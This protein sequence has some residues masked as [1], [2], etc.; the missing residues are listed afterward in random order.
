MLPQRGMPFRPPVGS[1]PPVGIPSRTPSGSLLPPKGVLGSPFAKPGMPSRNS[2]LGGKSALGAVR[3]PAPPKAPPTTL[4]G[5]KKY[6]TKVDMRQNIKKLSPFILKGKVFTQQQRAKMIEQWF[7]Y[8]KFGTHITEQK[9]KAVLRQLRR[10]ETWAKPKEK[11]PLKS[12]R[13]LL[14]AFTRVRKY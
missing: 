12:S 10:K 14:E 2:S 4:F 5:E 8:Q 9:T 11:R 1:R 13:K 3:R 7:P 6:W